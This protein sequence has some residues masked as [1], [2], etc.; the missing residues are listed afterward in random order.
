MHPGCGL[1]LFDR[2][3]VQEHRPGAKAIVAVQKDLRLGHNS[4][5]GAAPTRLLVLVG[6]ER[7]QTRAAKRLAQLCTLESLL[8][9]RFDRYL[10]CRLGGAQQLGALWV[11]ALLQAQAT[12]C[13][14][15]AGGNEFGEALR[16]AEHVEALQQFQ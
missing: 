1:F 4:P 11:F 5:R 2:A 15:L 10:S 12:T 3:P 14:H 7:L 13:I 6:L 9:Q 8:Q 16:A